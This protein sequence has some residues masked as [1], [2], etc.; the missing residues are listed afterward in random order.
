MRDDFL[1][2]PDP[3][4]RVSANVFAAFD[5]FKKEGLGLSIRDP[6]KGRNR[7]FQVGG[8]GL[9]NGHEVMAA[10]QTLKFRQRRGNGSVSRHKS[11]PIVHGSELE[12]Y[13]DFL[14]ARQSD[15]ESAPAYIIDSRID[16]P[17]PQIRAGSA[18]LSSELAQ[19]MI[20][21]QVAPSPPVIGGHVSKKWMRRARLRQPTAKLLHR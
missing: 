17:T 13:Q 11:T 16:S 12:K 6:Q 7:R 8:P 5:G 14:D 10:R 20:P 18:S 1:I 15:S 9:T 2:G 4:K 19:M 21:M 3:H